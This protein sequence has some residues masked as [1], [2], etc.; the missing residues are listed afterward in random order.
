MSATRPTTDGQLAKDLPGIT[1]YIT[2]HDEGSGETI[3]QHARPGKWQSVDN[4]GM[5]FNVAFTTSKFPV[6]M[7]E[8]AYIATHAPSI[9]T[10]SAALHEAVQ[11]LQASTLV[12]E[13]SA[14]QDE[15][16]Q[17]GDAAAWDHV[18]GD[19]HQHRDRVLLRGPRRRALHGCVQ[20][21]TERPHVVRRAHTRYPDFANYLHRSDGIHPPGQKIQHSLGKDV[22]AV[23]GHQPRPEQGQGTLTS[24]R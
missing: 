11:L 16:E 20:G 17:E 1:T 9:A 8:D 4:E 10:R 23:T 21:G 7:N 12:D 18:L 13:Y 6:S 24:I 22:V 15:W 19:V 2:G 14:A 5:A 3:V